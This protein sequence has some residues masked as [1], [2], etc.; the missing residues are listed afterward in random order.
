M[1]EK[2][3]EL[4]STMRLA[5]TKLGFAV[6]L[7]SVRFLGTFFT[8]INNIPNRVLIYM[9]AQL[10]VD[11]SEIHN[12]KRRQTKDEHVKLIKT[13][14]SY[15]DF[16]QPEIEEYL[17]NWLLNRATYTTES[18]DM[19]FD[20]L[21]KKCL[22][23]KIVLPGVTTFSRFIASTVEKAEEHLYQQLILVPSKEEQKQLLNLLDLIG[24]PVYG[25]TIKMDILRTQLVDDSRKEII[26]GFERLN[27]FQA[28]STEKWNIGSIPEGKIR[29]LAN[30]TFKAKAQLIQRMSGQ[31][32]LALLVAFV[33]IYKC[34]AM[35]EQ[36]LALSN[37]YETVFRRAK[38]TESKERLR[39]I[40]D[41][42]RAASTLSDIVELVMSDFSDNSELSI[43]DRVLEKYSEENVTDAVSQVRSLVKNNHEPT[44]IAELLNAYRKFRRFI[45]NI[46]TTLPFDSNNYGNNCK[47]LWS[48]ISN[49]FPK[50]ITYFEFTQ[51]FLY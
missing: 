33:Y 48:F 17:F 5:S 25:A 37:F 26:R 3:L 2:D 9:S 6:Q 10:N 32:K 24:S 50:P 44:A 39:T 12:Y 40:K 36:I 43:R 42:D 41:L 15:Q 20:M 47:E 22:D 7:V 14:Y 19:L 1:H 4:I 35:D 31:K 30:Y 28:F 45:P 8:N 23:E 29:V 11:P 16:N 18:S 27:Q 21:L 46:L 38:N 13:N 34:K 51:N 49:R